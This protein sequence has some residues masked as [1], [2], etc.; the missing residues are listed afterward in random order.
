M[1]GTPDEDNGT[2]DERPGARL[3][4]LFESFADEARDFT[5]RKPLEGLLLSFVAGLLLGDLLR[6]NR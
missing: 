5:R 2:D 1:R 4:Q 6:R 3:K